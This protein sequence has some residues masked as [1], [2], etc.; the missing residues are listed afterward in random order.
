MTARI[1][2]KY[3]RSSG[4][5]D[6]VKMDVIP[7]HNIKELLTTVVDFWEDGG[8]LDDF[9]F[10]KDGKAVDSFSTV[11][12]QGIVKGDTLVL[13][14]KDD[15]SR[16]E[17]SDVRRTTQRYKTA[18]QKP[19]QAA[20]RR[21]KRPSSGVKKQQRHPPIRGDEDV[22]VWIEEEIGV[23]RSALEIVERERL[24]NDKSLFELIDNSGNRFEMITQGEKV[25][26]YN[27]ILKG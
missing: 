14:R 1:K 27:P 26:H 8:E 16:T 9:L 4:E 13:K 24:D 20:A 15:F 25:I 6:D 23:P 21:Q 17:P 3:V 12:E 19:Q 10:V 11:A 18:N 2:I 7:E 5:E 22:K